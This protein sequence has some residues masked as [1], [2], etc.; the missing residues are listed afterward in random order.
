MEHLLD[1]ELK[2][3]AEQRQKLLGSALGKFVLISKDK[4]LGVFDTE[5]DAIRQGYLQLGNVPF[6]VKQVV[7]VEIA[8]NFVSTLLAV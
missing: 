7:E 4:I 3:Y 5:Q 2:T 1:L 8:Q 6:L